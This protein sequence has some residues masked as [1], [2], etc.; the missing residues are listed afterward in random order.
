MHNIHTYIHTHIY[1][2]IYIHPHVNIDI[3]E[4]VGLQKVFGDR[5]T[6]FWSLMVGTFRVSSVHGTDICCLGTTEIKYDDQHGLVV[7]TG[8]L[9]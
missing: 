4:N 9:L 2:Y 1:I 6:L 3:C 8:T 7:F 5:L